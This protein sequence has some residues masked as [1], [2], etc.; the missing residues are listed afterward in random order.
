MEVEESGH[1]GEPVST[2]LLGGSYQAKH[3]GYPIQVMLAA[4]LKKYEQ[5]ADLREQLL[6]TG[7]SVIGEANHRDW[8]WGIGLGLNDFDATD[9]VNWRGKNVL[10]TTLMFVREKL[11]ARG[12]SM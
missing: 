1:P 5:N 7:N 8:Y 11:R 6:E 2:V 3:S 4:T 12:S 9:P 10:G